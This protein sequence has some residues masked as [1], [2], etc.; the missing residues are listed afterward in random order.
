MLHIAVGILLTLLSAAFAQ[1][2]CTPSPGFYC[3]STTGIPI[4]C[5]PGYYCT[6]NAQNDHI[7]C[8]INTFNPNL[9]GSSLTSACQ[10]CPKFSVASTV[11]L[12]SCGVCAAGAYYSD[13]GGAGP[14]FAGAC[15]P[16][17]SGSSSIANSTQ[18]SSCLPGTYS[19]SLTQTCSLCR[20]GTY[21]DQPGFST[22]NICPSGTYTY[23]TA[24]NNSVFL[25]TWGAS[26]LAQ[27]L[28]L[29]TFGA[30]LMCLPGTYMKSGTCL[31]C[32]LGY[33]C[34]SMQIS[35]SD[36]TAVRAC[37]GGT[38]SSKS[39]AIS[40]TDCSVAS[41][42]QPYVFDAC[43]IAPGGSGAMNGLAVTASVTSLSSG[44]LFFT[45]A[46]A[47]YRVFLQA[48]FSLFFFGFTLAS[49][50]PVWSAN[51]PRALGRGGG[52]ERSRRCGKRHWH[53]CPLHVHHGHRP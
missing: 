48:R 26:S 27:C 31:P 13:N 40:A 38:M 44:T 39:G 9:G 1:Q 53:L 49:R 50:L 25:P 2:S 37:P 36:P 3:P 15:T 28:D 5:P 12:T 35:S 43:S 7:P 41:I 19:N 29:P 4:S 24:N 42:L 34:P 14:N 52:Y 23:T 11:G 46:T 18:C 47:L 21:Q 45:T 32:P 6:G 30:P 22:C 8:P 16:C 10:Y 51:H 20:P 33:Y 17:A